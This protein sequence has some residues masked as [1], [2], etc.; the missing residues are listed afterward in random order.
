MILQRKHKPVRSSKLPFF[1]FRVS[2]LLANGSVMNR[3]FQ[4]FETHIPFILQVIYLQYCVIYNQLCMPERVTACPNHHNIKITSQNKSKKWRHNNF[5]FPFKFLYLFHDYRN[6]VNLA[7][8]NRLFWWDIDIQSFC[9]V[10][11]F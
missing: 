10:T 11:T 1:T 5:E 9:D 8:Y 3:F 2:E 4:P 7:A 6:F